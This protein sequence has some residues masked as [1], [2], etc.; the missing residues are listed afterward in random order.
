MALISFPDFA[1]KSLEDLPH[2]YYI[3]PGSNGHSQ[4]IYCFHACPLGCFVA[5]W[6]YGLLLLRAWKSRGLYMQTSCRQ[7]PFTGRPLATLGI[8]DLKKIEKHMQ[9]LLLGE[10]VPVCF[11]LV[12]TQSSIQLLVFQDTS[13]LFEKKVKLIEMMDSSLIFD[14]F[15]FVWKCFYAF[16]HLKG[17]DP[18]GAEMREDRSRFQWLQQLAEEA[19]LGELDPRTWKGLGLSRSC[20]S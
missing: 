12:D 15:C 6:F 18:Y 2:A 4:G 9:R 10:Y 7:V 13:L 3:C 17:S 19:A 14:Y 20:F 5:S 16:G 8:L 11:V 1:K